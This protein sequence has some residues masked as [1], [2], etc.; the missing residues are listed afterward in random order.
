MKHVLILLP[1]L[2]AWSPLAHAVVVASGDSNTSAPAG[3]PYFNH[4]G[5]VNGASGIYLG[6]RWMLTA[7]HVAQALPTDSITLAGS[8][9]TA[10]ANSHLLLQ[11][12]GG[13]GLTTSTD[14]VLFR[15]TSDPGL[16]T[17]SIASASPT[18]GADVMMI[19]RGRDQQASRT[20]W[21]VTVVDG[22]N[23]DIWTTVPSGGHDREGY[24]TLET[25]SIRW[26]ENNVAANN[27]V[28]AFG[29]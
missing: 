16:P 17:L 10:E 7:A 26:G 25:R 20:Y 29:Q 15:L 2:L 18:M 1:A 22:P 3:Q 27:Q 5:I 4:I 21:D 19:G 24:L 8:N 11:N 28:Y 12:P 6:N 23:N 14:L 13:Y 9:Y